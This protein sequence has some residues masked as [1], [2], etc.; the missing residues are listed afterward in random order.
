MLVGGPD[1]RRI[2]QDDTP[3][4]D[5]SGVGHLHLQDTLLV[6]WVE[7]L[8][9]R[10]EE[11]PIQVGGCAVFGDFIGAVAPE[12][13][14]D[15][16]P[17][18]VGDQRWDGC[19]RDHRARKERLTEECVDQR[20]LPALELTEHGE[21]EPAGIKPVR[22]FPELVGVKGVLGAKR[23]NPVSFAGENFE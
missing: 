12:P 10:V 11:H 2:D 22:Q 18:A 14:P 3:C 5:R 17:V 4:K 15:A 21:V 23:L 6:L 16:P 20:A 19:Q 8:R 9:Y 13:D 7:F 1:P